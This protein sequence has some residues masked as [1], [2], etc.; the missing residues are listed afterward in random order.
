MNPIVRICRVIGGLSIVIWLGFYKGGG[1]KSTLERADVIFLLASIQFIYMIVIIT[2]K[3]VYMIKQWR[4][5]S[6]E[7]GEGILLM[8]PPFSFFY[9]PPP[10]LVVC[11]KTGCTVGAGTGVILGLGI[12]FDDGV[13]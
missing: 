8:I 4:K 2:I 6:L 11:V 12:G 10:K 1:D 5:G 7:G 9:S 3:V 13:F